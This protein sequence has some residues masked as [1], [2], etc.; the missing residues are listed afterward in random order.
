MARL[1]EV[2]KAKQ[3]LDRLNTDFVSDKFSSMRKDL[4]KIFDCIKHKPSEIDNIDDSFSA[5]IRSA[6]ELLSQLKSK[7]NKELE[8]W[9]PTAKLHSKNWCGSINRFNHDEWLSWRSEFYPTDDNLEHHIRSRLDQISD[10]Q[11]PCMV[12]HLDDVSR[13]SSLLSY[14][15]IYVADKFKETINDITHN[16]NV[17]QARK[18][19]L[20][21]LDHLDQLPNKSMRYIVSIN[22][23]THIDEDKILDELSYLFNLLLPGGIIAFNFNDCDEQ[24]CAKL[25]EAGMRSFARGSS[26][27]KFINDKNMIIRQY[28]IL[29]P[30]SAYVEVKKPGNYQSIKKHEPLG[31]LKYN[32]DYMIR[33]NELKAQFVG[34]NEEQLRDIIKRERGTYRY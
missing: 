20:Y 33:L 4:D 24:G 34:L 19:R 1:S 12:Y 27:K 11:G 9:I 32:E 29:Q 13:I 17:Q 22:H 18:I 26:L 5:T 3:I 2:I 21:D 7:I 31:L 16:F 25:F 8:S 6:D 30:S 10:W 28:K 23:F 14:Y 15:P